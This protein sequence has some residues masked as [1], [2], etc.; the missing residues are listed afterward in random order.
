MSGQGSVPSFC[1]LAANTPGASRAAWLLLGVLVTSALVASFLLLP[2][3]SYAVP[4]SSQHRSQG[5]NAL[6]AGHQWVGQ[7]HTRTEYAEFATRLKKNGIT[8]VFFHVGPLNAAGTIDQERYPNAVS[9]IENVKQLYPEVRLQAWIG[10]IEMKGG[11]PLGLSDDDVRDTIVET[12]T[13]FLDLGFDGIH[14]N[15]EPVFSDD[16][17]FI[18]LLQRTRRIAEARGNVVSVAADEL[19]PF[20]GAER[21]VRVFAK[22]AG[23]WNKEYYLEVAASVDQIAVMMYDTALPTPWLYGTLVEWETRSLVHLVG[24]QVT[25]FMGVPSYEDERWSFNPGAENV[26]SALRGIQ[27]GLEHLADDD[28]EK[29]GVAIYAEWTT[30]E[31]EWQLYRQEWLS[32]Q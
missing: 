12:A 24:D 7:D 21:L 1:G 22:Q 3:V 19:E 32:W 30:D 25:L 31:D 17:D 6:W 11:G 14:Y 29:F 10:Q 8:D 16:R 5:Q 26:Q 23:F 13:A 2:Y 4:I 15:I 27:K 28:I 20:W 9:L 18:D